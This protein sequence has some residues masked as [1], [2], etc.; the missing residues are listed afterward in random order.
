MKYLRL[1]VF[2]TLFFTLS[3]S[4]AKPVFINGIA[5][6]VDNDVITTQE[7]QDQITNIKKQLLSQGTQLPPASIL[8]K[9]VLEREIM[10]RIQ[11][12]LAAN[13][14][15]RVD[16]TELNGALNRIAQQNHMDLRELK[17]TLENEG[18]DFAQYREMIRDD[19]IMARLRQREVI[20]RITISDQEV[21]NF[22]ATQA[23]QGNIDEEYNVSQILISVPEAATAKQIAETKVKAEQVLNKLDHGAD[24][25]QVAISESRGQNALEGGKLGWR[26]A[27]QLPTIFAAVITQMNVGEH[28]GLIRSSSG[29]HIIRLNDK[30][31]GKKHIV[32]QYKVRHILIKPS[33]LNT[34][35]EILSRLRQ[36]RQRIMAGASFSAL[37]KS[38]SDDPGSAMQGGELGWVS[39]GQ[40][41]PQFEAVMKSLKVGEI[42]E[43]FQTQFGWH[44]MQVEDKREIDDSKNFTENNAREFIRQRKTEEMTEAWLRQL[45]DEAYVEIKDKS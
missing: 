21:K 32:T 29:F 3:L 37:A 2:F 9:Q 44:I 28:S 40:M 22:I 5:A 4:W 6:I 14:G 41:V 39:P 45:R 42:S 38:H 7:L 43:P 19:M 35:A 33:E 36:L 25:S 11:L 30:R 17:N 27:G 31:S 34:E 8:R 13:T 1:F 26:K 16:D 12:H 10:K 18:F 24:F 15:I 23:S 20:N